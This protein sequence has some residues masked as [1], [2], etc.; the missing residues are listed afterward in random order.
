MQRLIA[1]SI[2]AFAA[3]CQA[4]TGNFSVGG[5]ADAAQ[6]SGDASTASDTGGGSTSDTTAAAEAGACTVSCPC[7]NDSDCT[8]A[9]GVQGICALAAD[10][11]ADLGHTGFCS[12]P[13]CTSANCDPGS[14]CF[15]SGVGG[16]YCVNPAW[17]VRSSTLGGS[18]GGATCT[19]NAQCRSGLCAGGKCAD[20]CCSFADSSAQCASG[21][22]CAF[23]AFP[24]TSPDIHF[25]PHCGAPGGTQTTG[26]LCTV[27]SECAGGLCYTDT[28]NPFCVAPCS[29]PGECGGGFA[30]QLDIQSGDIYAGC[31]QSDGAT[32]QGASC[33]NYMQC[34]GGLCSAAGECTNICFSDSVCE[35][36]WRCLPMLDDE[37]PAGDP[38]VLA[39]GP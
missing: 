33:T 11:G 38:T 36:G 16:N 29:S 9:K 12:Q 24:G 23:G 5:G 21:T 3:A 39:C 13:C 22:E 26:S 7:A 4:V 34:L 15:A 8:T 30:C 10:V 19:S 27:S 25:A 17:L 6:N 31:F 35:G 37:Y 1:V 18:I 14:V 28:A 32:A 20:T 2:V